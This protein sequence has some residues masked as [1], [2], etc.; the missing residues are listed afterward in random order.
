MLKRYTPV[1]YITYTFVAGAISLCVYMPDLIVQ[2]G[3]ASSGALAGAIYLG[4]LGTATPYALWSYGISKSNISR[5]VVFQYAI[6]ILATAIGYTVLG[7]ISP[8]MAFWGGMIALLG[9][10]VSNLPSRFIPFFGMHH[11]F[12][13]LGMPERQYI[14][15]KCTAPCTV[16]HDG[17]RTAP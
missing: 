15:G 6:P 13:L 7:E 4:L 14:K 12:S 2:L 8:N 11:L 10:I 16:R 1:E 3:V 5:I 17:D 9:A